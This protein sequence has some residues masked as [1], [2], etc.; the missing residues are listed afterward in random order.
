MMLT[1]MKNRFI[2]GFRWISVFAFLAHTANANG[3]QTN[4][5]VAPA[6]QG[7]PATTNT[8]PAPQKPQPSG[9]DIQLKKKDEW[10]FSRLKELVKRFDAAS[11]RGVQYPIKQVETALRSEFMFRSDGNIH[12]SWLFSNSLTFA[13]KLVALD[14]L[15]LL[16]DFA[17]RSISIAD[18]QHRGGKKK[19]KVVLEDLD[20]KLLAAKLVVDEQNKKSAAQR[21]LASVD[22]NNPSL[23]STGHAEWMRRKRILGSL[24]AGEDYAGIPVQKVEDIGKRYREILAQSVKEYEALAAAMNQGLEKRSRPAK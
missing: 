22:R 2:K 20:L 12:I 11:R 21:G 14:N 10:V 18:E 24:V 1:S 15:D 7:A 16:I 9:A 5:A 23:T 6:Q 4:G 19:K 3:P 17:E 8:Q 13:D